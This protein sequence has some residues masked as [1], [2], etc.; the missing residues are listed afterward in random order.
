MN[1]LISSPQNLGKTEPL[2]Y[3]EATRRAGDDAQR[4]CL[5]RRGLRATVPYL[6]T[7]PEDIDISVEAQIP[8]N[9]AYTGLEWAEISVERIRKYLARYHAAKGRD[10]QR[11]RRERAGGWIRPFRSASPTRRS[12][13]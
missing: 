13:G 4:R 2:T 10:H 11:E 5:A 1:R 3:I 9:N 7:L 6:D 12:S 8:P